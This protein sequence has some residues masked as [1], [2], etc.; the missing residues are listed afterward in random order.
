MIGINVLKMVV[1]TCFSERYNCYYCDFDLCSDCI[2]RMLTK[3][4]NAGRHGLDTQITVD[5]E[6]EMPRV[7]RVLRRIYSKCEIGIQTSTENVSRE[8]SETH[9]SS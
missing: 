6:A 4:S 3:N 8:M 1:T 7:R 2:T 5:N 9:F